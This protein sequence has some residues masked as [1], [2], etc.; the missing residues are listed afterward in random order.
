MEL[1][2]SKAS[3]PVIAV[4]IPEIRIDIDIPGL[5][6]VARKFVER[7]YTLADKTLLGGKDSISDLDFL[8]GTKSA[9]CLRHKEVPFGPK[10]DS[11]FADTDLGIMILGDMNKLYLVICS[12][13]Q[14]CSI[15]LLRCIL[16][17]CKI[18]M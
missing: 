11:I 14:G 12:F 10:E 5:T 15:A 2:V 17:F 8:L 9:Y 13:Y 4:C 7:G 18:R 6:K 1:S 3:Y 16:L